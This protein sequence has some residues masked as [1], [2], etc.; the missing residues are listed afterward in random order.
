[1]SGIQNGRPGL[2][3]ALQILSGVPGGIDVKREAMWNR[4]SSQSKSN[5]ARIKSNSRNPPHPLKTSGAFHFVSCP[6]MKGIY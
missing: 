1:M 2:V 4:V 5:A 3:R 6:S